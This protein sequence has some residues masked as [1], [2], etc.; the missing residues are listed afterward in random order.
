[1]QASRRLRRERMSLRS[2]AEEGSDAAEGL[3]HV[4]LL[5]TGRYDLYLGPDLKRCLL[6]DVHNV[7]L[8]NLVVGR[9]A[10]LA[11]GRDHLLRR[12]HLALILGDTFLYRPA[13]LALHGYLGRLD[14]VR[15][16]DG[17]RNRLLQRVE[18]SGEAV[19]R[20]TARFVDLGQKSLDE[21]LLLNQPHVLQGIGRLLH[22]LPHTLPPRVRG[23]NDCEDILLQLIVEIPTLQ[24]VLLRRSGAPGDQTRDLGVIDEDPRSVLAH[25]VEVV[26]EFH[27]SRPLIATSTVVQHET[28]ANETTSYGKLDIDELVV[29]QIPLPPNPLHFC[30][31]QLALIYHSK[32]RYCILEEYEPL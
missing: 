16:Q 31:N 28:V 13:V 6:Q 30:E 2:V 26:G 4:S 19:D 20:Q 21:F 29:A 14:I 24:E 23:V 17:I 25:P 5:R 10:L 12:L 27:L 7:L 3:E 32:L 22:E 9:P 15:D 1:M 8:V 11:R 18:D